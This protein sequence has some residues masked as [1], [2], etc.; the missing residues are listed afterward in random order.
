[1]HSGP[2]VRQA[3][4]R[5]IEVLVTRYEGPNLDA[6]N[7]LYETEDTLTRYLPKEYDGFIKYVQVKGRT[8][9]AIANHIS[10]S[11]PNPTF[12]VV[13]PPGAFA[14]YFSGHNTEG[15]TL[16]EMAGKPIPAIDAFRSA[17]PRLRPPRRDGDRRGIDVPDPGQPHRGQ[18]PGRSRHDVHGDPRL[19]PVA[20]RRVDVRLPASDLRHPG[21]EPVPARARHRRARVGARARGQGR[22]PTA[23]PGGGDERHQIPFSG[24]VRPVLAKVAESGILVAM[25][26]SDSGYQRHANEWEGDGRDMQP[27]APRPFTDA[28][29]TGRPISDTVTSAICHGMLS[30]FRRCGSRVSRTGGVGPCPA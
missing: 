10:E 19:Q 22:A 12:E 2:H 1:M 7:H 30:R 11:I 26:A 15:K 28:V 29:N 5:R 20:P 6:D 18:S 3:V 21:G 24:R 25:H 13:A 17:E 9:I 14:Q 23:W 16:R 4:F 8:K 27:F